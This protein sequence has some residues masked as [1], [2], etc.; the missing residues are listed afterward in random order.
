[1]CRFFQRFLG[2]SVTFLSLTLLRMTGHFVTCPSLG[3]CLMFPYGYIQVM[4]LCRDVTEVTLCSSC[5]SYQVAHNYDLSHC[6]KMGL[7]KPPASQSCYR[8]HRRH[9]PTPAFVMIISSAFRGRAVPTHTCLLAQSLPCLLELA[10]RMEGTHRSE[11]SS[12]ISWRALMPA[13]PDLL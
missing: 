1:M 12:Q 6:W 11:N 3:I 4:H 5:V 9:S 13:P 2:L 8:D 10:T 7:R